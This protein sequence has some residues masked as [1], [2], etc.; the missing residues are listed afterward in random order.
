MLLAEGDLGEVW[1]YGDEGDVGACQQGAGSM[2]T[3]W[4]DFGCTETCHRFVGLRS[5]CLSFFLTFATG[6]FMSISLTAH[7][8]LNKCHT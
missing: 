3:E 4:D 7:H 1:I 5:I 6:L 2:G 8:E